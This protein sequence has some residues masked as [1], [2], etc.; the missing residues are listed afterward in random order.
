M[1]T[2]TEISKESL[3]GP[4]VYRRVSVPA[5]IPQQGNE[6]SCGSE[7]A[8]PVRRAAG[9]TQHSSGKATSSVK[10]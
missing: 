10:S 8:A 4:A 5:S 6:W 7:A 2:F 1:A 3:G 9:K